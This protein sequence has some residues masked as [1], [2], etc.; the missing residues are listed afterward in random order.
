MGPWYH[1]TVGSGLPADGVQSL[2]ALELRWMDRYLRGDN[3]ATL[4]TD[5]PPVTYYQLGQG[6]YQTASTWPPAAVQYHE[7]FLGGNSVGAQSGTLSSSKGSATPDTMVWQP[8]SGVCSRSTAQW[9]AAG[10]NQGC[11]E[12]QRANDATGLTYDLSVGS[13]GLKLAGPVNAHLFVSTTGADAFVTARLE[14]V[15]ADGK[16]TQISAGWSVL[17]LRALDHAKTIRRNGMIVRPYHPFTRESSLPVK[18]GTVYTLDVE[19][20]PTA[21]FIAP[22]HSLRLSIQPSDAPH[23]TPSVPQL[24]NLAGNVLSLYHDATH[25][26]S[27]ALPLQ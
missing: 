21:G 8:A 14:D 26:S 18:A 9:T 3:D 17:S 19:I 4:D 6:H 15:A 1:A 24:A 7:S 20:F 5:V 10:V 23:L 25:P 22:G 16:A 27:V 12:D 2:D 13:S 11:E